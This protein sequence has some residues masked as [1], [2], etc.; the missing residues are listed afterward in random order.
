MFTESEFI[1]LGC[2]HSG[3]LVHYNTNAAV[4]D[5]GPDQAGSELTLIDCGYTI[6]QALHHAGLGIAGIDHIIITHVHGDHVFGLERVA[7]ETRFKYGRK[8]NLYIHPSIYEELWDHTLKG[9]LGQNSDGAASLEDY[10]NVIWLDEET[11]IGRHRYQL[12]EVCHS[13]G[14][15]TFGL[16]IDNR[17]FYSADTVAIPDIMQTLDFEIGFHDVTL[18]PENPVHATL[19]SLLEAY[20][21]AIR[22]KLFLMS[23]EDNW[24]EFEAVV[25]REFRGFAKQGMRLHLDH[26][27]VS[28]LS[29][30]AK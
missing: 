27:A 3:S 19:K 15:P 18:T 7:F 2:G 20:P 21:G 5:A 13:P 29:A 17:I 1:V 10:F 14:K 24:Q 25:N 6:K 11:V 9:S 28:V 8:V 26:A 16:L 30:A 22:E 23:Y 4:L 12:I